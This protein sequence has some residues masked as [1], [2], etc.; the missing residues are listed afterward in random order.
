MK[1]VNLVRLALANGLVAVLAPRASAVEPPIVP[2][3]GAPFTVS[4]PQVIPN[5]AL[6]LA[7]KTREDESEATHERAQ[8][9]AA[10]N[11]AEARRAFE[12]P[13]PEMQRAIAEHVY[14][15]RLVERQSR[16]PLA[17]VG[18]RSLGPTQDAGR[19][20]DYAF[21][22]DGSRMYVATSNGGLWRLTRQGGP[23]SDYGNPQSLTDDLPL[24]TFGAVAVAPS[25]PNI[26]YAATGEASHS[27]HVA[28]GFGTLLSTDGGNT[29]SFNTQSV[30]GGVNDV[31]PSQYSFKIDVNPNDPADALLGTQN[32][33]FRTRDSGRT[34]V[35]KLAAQN[36]PYG[37]R[38][39]C[40]LARRPGNASVVWAGLWGGLGVSTDGGETW[41]VYL[42]DVATQVGYP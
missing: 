18:W 17:T 15:Q 34:W 14:A 5:L 25:N 36:P 13:P 9:R 10:R 35:Q 2:L 1:R 24:L 4:G 11:E 20:S 33:I 30:T 3:L 29:W 12:M 31:I 22:S 21:T 32:G 40:S 6:R 38:Q 26:V 7:P 27:A 8:F 37:K 42:E 28:A 23:G 41:T 39:G 19:V 16:S